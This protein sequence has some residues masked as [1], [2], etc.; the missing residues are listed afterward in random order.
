MTTEEIDQL[1]AAYESALSHSDKLRSDY[2][3][4]LSQRVSDARAAIVESMKPAMAAI[5]QANRDTNDAKAAWDAAL[6]AKSAA[7]A[8]AP[9][10]IGTKLFQWAEPNSYRRSVP[11]KLTGLVGVVEVWTRTSQSPDGTRNYSLPNPGDF[12]IRILKKDGTPG[13]KF[14]RYHEHSKSWGTWSETWLPEGVEP[15]ATP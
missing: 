9:V 2:D 13:K 6:E 8:G 10:P 3:R 14:I 5:Y 1:E 15:R 12:I 11:K 7:G 4:V